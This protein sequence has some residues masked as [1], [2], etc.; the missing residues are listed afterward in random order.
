MKYTLKKTVE[1]LFLYSKNNIIIEVNDEFLNLTGHFRNELIGKSLEEISYMLRIDSQIYLENIENEHSCY[2][3]TKEYEA[4]EVFI[5][6][7][8]LRE[9]NEKIYFFKE[10]INSHIE[11]KF[12]VINKLLLDNQVGIGIYA[13]PNLIL[14]KGNQY[15]LDLICSSYNKKETTIGKKISDFVHS[16]KDSKCENIF[17]NVI[18]TGQSFYGKEIKGFAQNLEEF[19]VNSNLIPIVENGKIK[20][21][22]SMVEDVTEKVLLRKNNEE[23]AKV[24]NQ[25]KE[26]FEIIIKNMSDGLSIIDKDYNYSFLNSSAKEFVYNSDLLK[27]AGD[28]LVHTKYY[29]SDGKLLKYEELPVV[30][31]LN[32][33][34]LKG[35][36]FTSHRPDGLYHYNVSGSPIYDE[37]GNVEKVI[38]CCR[39]V[40]ERVN[41]DEVIKKQKEELEAIIENMSDGLFIIDKEGTYI[42]ANKLARD[43]FLISSENHAIKNV[44]EQ[45]KAFDA[46]GNLICR[47]NFPPSKIMRGEKVFAQR[48]TIK[49]KDKVIYIEVNA[50]PIYDKEGNFA[51]GVVCVRDITEQVRKDELIK[52]QKDELIRIQNVQLETI[53]ENIYDNLVVFNK[54]GDI[55]RYSK[56]IENYFKNHSEIIN[57]NDYFRNMEVSDLDGTSF[58][59]EISIS[60]GKRIV[61]GERILRYKFAAKIN[62]N[63]FY[64]ELNANPIFDCKGNFVAGVIMS[65]DIT[66]EVKYRNKIEKNLKIQD[67][68]FAN[69]SHELKTPLNVIYS[70]NQLIELY[71]KNSSFEENKEKISKSLKVIKQNC[72]RFSKLINNIVDLS[73]IDSGFFKLNLVNENIVSVIEDIVESVAEYI[74]GKGIDIF[75]DTNTEEKIIACDSEKIERIILNL[76]SNAIKFTNSGGII[77]VDLI[78]RVGTIEIVI[79]DTG[80]GIDKKHLD[81]I[82]KRFYQADKSLT[83]NAEGSGIGLSLV[84]SLL[85]LHDGKISIESIVGEGSVFK[86]EL[87]TRTIEDAEEVAIDRIMSKDNK[88]ERINIEFSDIYSI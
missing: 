9:E 65:R 44:D 68:V 81:S 52:M 88:V 38:H 75:F 21:I 34:K 77:S 48:F 49:Q 4:R 15:Y 16:F 11:D 73:K 37:N 61:N 13:L 43:I 69:I 1:K 7:K 50:T 51:A 28:S 20:Y 76:I 56:T 60:L 29:D 80:I 63:V 12:Q 26:E 82:F 8:L 17:M 72:Y 74:K 35:F 41:K 39:D 86:I 71:L 85:E 3:F 83:R 64:F 53:I 22:V 10:K 78:D 19:Y 42:A 33:E 70:T 31:L 67:E 66:E 46:K 32:G 2:I 14:L 23:Q 18:N 30:R 55:I 87:P 45:I 54:D 58:S 47:E 5:T 24:I 36:E 27:K 57:V 25:Q 40:T 62:D 79:K 59:E 6:Y 84:K